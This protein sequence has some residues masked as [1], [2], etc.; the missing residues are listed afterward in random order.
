METQ[1]PNEKGKVEEST[2]SN[3]NAG[4]QQGT[5]NILE[6]ARSLREGIARDMAQIAE[7]RKVIEEA[8]TRLILGGKAQAGMPIKTPQEQEMENILKEAETRVKNFLG[9]KK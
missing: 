9:R 4:I 3:S 6:E 5:T 2:P 1:Q 7:H 8:A